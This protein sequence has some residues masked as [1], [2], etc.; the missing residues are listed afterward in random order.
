MPNFSRDSTP[1]QGPSTALAWCCLVAFAAAIAIL[2]GSSR[3]DVVQI[4][5]LRPVA[6]LM[7]IPAL[8]FASHES[9]Q[10]IRAPAALLS[11]LA[12]WMALQIVPLPPAMWHALPDR[13]IIAQL[14]EITGAS[15]Q[16]RPISMVPSRTVNALAGLV[17][18]IAA[19]ALAVGLRFNQHQLFVL[20]AGLGAVD[21]LLGFAQLLTGAS[22][23]FYFYAITNR[24]FA[25]GLFAN[26]NHSAVF[27]SIAML[28]SVRLLLTQGK[29]HQTPW[30]R[31]FGAAVFT[32]AL[33]AV[34]VSGSRAGLAVALVAL[35]T[36]IVMIYLNA[37]MRAT[38]VR[39]P[40]KH[41]R[42]GAGSRVTAFVPL[43]F[44]SDPR[45][46]AT[47]FVSALIII[48]ALFVLSGRAAG[49]EQVI[50]QSAFDDLRWRLAPVL[51]SMAGRHWILGSGFGSFE[52]VYH[53]YEPT[54]LLV[55]T[56]I[57]Q[58]GRAHV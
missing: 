4:V 8:Y 21:A 43:H 47:I 31:V 52:E 45:K 12:V 23:P 50:N 46:L 44:F 3:P 33:L 16:W 34:I 42:T 55:A 39:A 1:R 6:A 19:L 28:A 2:G 56:Y 58:I 49:L 40:A 20:I 11:L 37:S 32:L 38:K 13:D 5:V 53:I 15:E 57:N 41:N 30:L 24:G 18:P 54:Q 48:A 9:I 29:A 25:V 22:G 7:L 51:Q 26:E 35:A 36:S 14:D 17:V 27:S 10:P